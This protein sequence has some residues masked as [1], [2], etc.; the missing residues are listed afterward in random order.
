M[1]LLTWILLIG[2]LV[3]I[4]VLMGCAYF[5]MQCAI[6][7]INLRLTLLASSRDLHAQLDKL[8]LQ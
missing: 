6:E 4:V 5:L 1:L 2:C 8:T 7:L 3:M